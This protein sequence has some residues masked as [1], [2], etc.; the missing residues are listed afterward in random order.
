MAFA[1]GTITLGT[2]NK[3]PTLTR[4][5]SFFPCFLLFGVA[6]IDSTI[7]SFCL[8]SNTEMRFLGDLLLRREVA[9]LTGAL[10][11]AFCTSSGSSSSPSRSGFDRDITDVKL[12][13]RPGPLRT[14]L[15]DTENRWYP[16]LPLLI[17]L[18]SFCT[19]DRVEDRCN[20][21]GFACASVCSGSTSTFAAAL[22][23]VTNEI[24]PCL[25]RVRP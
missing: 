9:V 16:S 18:E 21:V 23:H 20:G 25:R 3:T 2:C 14:G 22:L 6:Y 5:Q 8:R 4:L 17:P 12:P 24:L 19:S 13:L 10:V 15:T 1:K 7:F 11:T